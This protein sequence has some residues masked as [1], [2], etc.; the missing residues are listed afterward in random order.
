[1]IY[2]NKTSLRKVLCYANFRY[3]A[4]QQIEVMDI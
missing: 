3:D 2:P 1:M 4:S